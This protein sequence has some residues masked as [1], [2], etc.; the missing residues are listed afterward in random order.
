[1]SFGNYNSLTPMYIQTFI[2]IKRIY[3]CVLEVTYYFLALQYF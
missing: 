3:M 1:M 2:G